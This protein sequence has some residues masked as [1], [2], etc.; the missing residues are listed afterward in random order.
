[1]AAPA[2]ALARPPPRPCARQALESLRLQPGQHVLIHAGAG[3]LGSVAIQLARARFGLRVTTT[4]ST[5]HLAFVKQASA[6]S[7]QAGAGLGREGPGGA[8]VGEAVLP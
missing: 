2:R 7:G 3:G 5:R 8:G 4:C 1:M 6:S